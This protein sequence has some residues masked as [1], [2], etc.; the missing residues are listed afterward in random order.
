MSCFQEFAKGY[1]KTN[2]ILFSPLG[3]QHLENKTKC[4]LNLRLNTKHHFRL[5]NHMGT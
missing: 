3:S 4:I 1:N 2:K 5:N